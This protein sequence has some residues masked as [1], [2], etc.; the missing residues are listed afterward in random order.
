L[1]ADYE[2]ALGNVIS[3]ELTVMDQ[4]VTLV[5]WPNDNWPDRM[6]KP[7]ARQ[8]VLSPVDDRV[9]LVVFNEPVRETTKVHLVAGLLEAFQSLDPTSLGSLHGGSNKEDHEDFKKFY[10]LC[11]TPPA[12]EYTP[13]PHPDQERSWSRVGDC[14]PYLE[15]LDE[16]FFWSPLYSLLTGQATSAVYVAPH[17]LSKCDVATYP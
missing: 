1:A 8:A 3:Y 4:N 17:A 16:I 5:A 6:P 13:Y 11:K 10:G 15:C 12:N 9:T 14:E 2:Q 7:H